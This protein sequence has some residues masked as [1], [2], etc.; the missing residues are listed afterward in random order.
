MGH[1][2]TLTKQRAI[3][4]L[5][6]RDRND[7][8]VTQRGE[9]AEHSLYVVRDQLDD[10]IDVFREPQISMR[11]DRKSSGDEI[12]NPPASSAEARASKLESFTRR[13][14]AHSRFSNAKSQNTQKMLLAEIWSV[15][16]NAQ[17]HR[18]LI[19]PRGSSLSGP[20]KLV[21]GGRY[22]LY[23]K[24][25]LKIQVVAASIATAPSA[26]GGRHVARRWAVPP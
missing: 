17:I 6:H 7:G 19:R 20:G 14:F 23:S 21:A 22:E 8:L 24:Y 1:G 25:S 9:G 2:C 16:G 11:A 26:A 5:L 15:R 18:G 10:D 4:E 12:A 13:G 3:R